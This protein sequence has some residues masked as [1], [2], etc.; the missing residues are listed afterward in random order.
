MG[1]I[2]AAFNQDLLLGDSNNKLSPSFN[3]SSVFILYR[4]VNLYIN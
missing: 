1:M 2:K 3:I 4:L